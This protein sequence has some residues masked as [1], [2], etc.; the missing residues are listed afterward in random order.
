M[1]HYGGIYALLIACQCTAPGK[2]QSSLSFSYFELVVNSFHDPI[3][4]RIFEI[5]MRIQL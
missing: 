3:G 4:L 5:R 1:S 2:S